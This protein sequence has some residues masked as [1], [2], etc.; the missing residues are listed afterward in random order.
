[1]KKVLK[2]A[3]G[4][5]LANQQRKNNESV[6]A[7]LKATDS[8]ENTG[9]GCYVLYVDIHYNNKDYLFAA[10]NE[11]YS[12]SENTYYNLTYNMEEDEHNYSDLQ[13]EEDYCMQTNEDD[14][15]WQIEINLE[16]YLSVEI[17]EYLTY[18]VAEYL[19]RY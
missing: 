8:I 18:R 3:D 11:S 10:D 16:S 15:K 6:K 19:H 2:V 13:Y 14:E 12:L 5:Q 17:I 7:A 4:K 9:G 1:M